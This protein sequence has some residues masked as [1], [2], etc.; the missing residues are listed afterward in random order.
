MSVASRS[1]T[2]S[3][4][5]LGVRLEVEVHQQLVDRLCRVADLVIACAAAREFEPVERA[6]ARKGTV[7]F[8]LAG[9]QTE[10]GIGEQLLVIVE[11]FVAQGQPVDALR[12]HL[13]QLVLDQQGRVAIAKTAC[14]PP[15]QVDL[16]IHLAQQLRPTIAG[17]LASR[18]PG[19]HAAR[20]RAVNPNTSWLHSVIG[21][22]ASTRQQP[23]LRQRSY[24][25][26][27]RPFQLLSSPRI[28]S[29]PTPREKCGLGCNI[30]I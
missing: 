22:A 17:H 30:S 25:M 24:A 29:P 28:Y 23:R 11:V 1:S 16:A 6:L 3:L 7:Q 18:E 4:W 2:I 19:L 15:Q 12:K 8:A 14:Q 27:R 20:K 21:K 13:R 26:K 10:Q 5:R 9:Q